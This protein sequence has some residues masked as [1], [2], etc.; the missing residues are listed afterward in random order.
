MQTNQSLRQHLE[1]ELIPDIEVI[2]HLSETNTATVFLARETA[3]KRLVAV[4]V[5][6]PKLSGNPKA[7][8]RFEREAQAAAALS[9]PNVVSVHGVGRLSGGTP[10]IVMQHVKGRTIADRLAAEGPLPDDDVRRILSAVASALTAAHKQGIVHRDVTPRAIMEEQETGRVL[11]T[12]FGIAAV[13]ATGAGSSDGRLTVA[14]E[15]LGNP[16]Y[17]SPEQR[18]GEEVS[19]RSDVYSLG[20]VGLELLTDDLYSVMPAG[21]GLAEARPNASP[22]LVRILERCLDPDPQRRPPAPDIV[23]RLA[24]DPAA[25]RPAG[26]HPD[27]LPPKTVMEDLS[28]RRLP[29]WLGAYVVSGF[30]LLEGMDMT[31]DR[32]LLPEL[33]WR[34]YLVA[35]CCGIPVTAILAWFHGAPGRQ[36]VSARELSLLALMGVVWLVISGIVA[37]M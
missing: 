19:D 18:R 24:Q 30:M 8:A 29:Q 25:A 32:G 4:K 17:I 6:S 27:P 31:V 16:L 13:M 9:H 7:V 34:L 33:A 15:V 11:L 22:A 3:L 21:A 2:R 5:L 23:R 35:Y 28:L 1:Q 10:Y 26:D 37:S 14:G 12:D 20:V 36:K